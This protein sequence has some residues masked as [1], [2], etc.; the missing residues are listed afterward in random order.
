MAYVHKTHPKLNS[1][2]LRIIVVGCGGNGSKLLL[3]LADLSRTLLALGHP[4]IHVVA[5]DGDRVTEPNLARQ[6]F[7][8]ADIGRPKSTTLITRINMCYGLGWTAHCAYVG[9]RK[10]ADVLGRSLLSQ[11]VVATC[12]D[13]RQARADVYEA[14]EAVRAAYALDLGNDST[15]GQF[16][17][18]TLGRGHS[19]HLP[20]AVEMWPEIADPTAAG[21]GDDGPSCS[22]EEAV[23]RQD[24]FVHDVLTSAAANTLW[25][26]IRDG[27]I[28]HHGA[29]VN[30]VSGVTAPIPVPAPTATAA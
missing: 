14:T 7:T 12:V 4:G 11:D 17:L 20:T 2:Q 29:F 13:S 23:R 28:E 21:P 24:P 5:I 30:L 6:P 1:G 16:A 3:R 9:A 27:Q 18:G 25:R 10:G 22:S 15:T 8:R 26:L 19:S